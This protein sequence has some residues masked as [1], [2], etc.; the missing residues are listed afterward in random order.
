MTNW[1]DATTVDELSA[2]SSQLRDIID[3]GTVDSRTT[4]LLESVV[5]HL[6]DLR[7]LVDNTNVT[8]EHANLA[9]DAV[10]VFSFGRRFL[11][12]FEEELTAPVDIEISRSNKYLRV[13]FQFGQA[14]LPNN[15]EQLLQRLKERLARMDKAALP[16]L[17]SEFSTATASLN[18]W[19]DAFYPTV[20]DQ[21]ADISRDTTMRLLLAPQI[22]TLVLERQTNRLRL[23]EAEAQSA[24]DQIRGTA[25]DAGA[26]TMASVFKS[27]ADE[28]KGRAVL[29]TWLLFILMAFGIALP[30]L[31]LS[32][33]VD[34][35]STVEGTTGMIIKALIG[36]P[37]YALAIF[38]ASSAE[39]HRATERHFRLLKVQVDT[40]GM[41]STP[42]GNEERSE[43]FMLLGRRLF[44]N[45]ELEG[46]KETAL[47]IV[48]AE[49]IPALEKLTEVVK[50]KS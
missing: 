32:T 45:P 23:F 22:Q 42:L 41:Y 9:T 2:G 19:R 8:S 17:I 21:L 47:S 16:E 3:A 35:F 33:S 49:L 14:F 34:L 12:K 1:A 6:K 20:L 13:G 46:G 4:E 29:W 11:D 39:R 24:V 25:G 40:V 43:I 44:S 27:A 30:V 5:Q 36:L 28:E 26:A 10:A 48:P 15:S 50:P 31:A 37:F 7:Y 38:S 18:S